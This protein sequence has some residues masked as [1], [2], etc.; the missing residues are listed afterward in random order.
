MTLQDFAGLLTG[1]YDSITVGGF[2]MTL[3]RD[4]KLTVH[5]RGTDY[6]IPLSDNPTEMY[7]NVKKHFNL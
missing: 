2:P 3:S 5:Y 4:G 7:E 1:E 6:D